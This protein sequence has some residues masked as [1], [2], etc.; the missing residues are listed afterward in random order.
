MLSV[1]K[2][3]PLYQVNYKRCAGSVCQHDRVAVKKS[4]WGRQKFSCVLFKDWR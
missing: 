1:V 4:N 2:Q 3:D